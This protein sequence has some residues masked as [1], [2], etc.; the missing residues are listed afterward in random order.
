MMHIQDVLI[1]WNRP[2]YN[3]NNNVYDN[4]NKDN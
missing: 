3:N 4:D 2:M 1:P